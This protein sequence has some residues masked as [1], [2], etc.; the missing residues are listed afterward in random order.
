MVSARFLSLDALFSHQGN[1]L[2]L[3]QSQRHPKMGIFVAVRGLVHDAM[4]EADN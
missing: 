2:V 1:V 3:R 4:I